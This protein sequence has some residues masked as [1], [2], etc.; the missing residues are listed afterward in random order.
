MMLEPLL[1][2]DTKERILLFLVVRG[3]GYAA[4]IARFYGIAASS[5]HRQLDN[6]EYG[7][8]LIGRQIG[9]CRDFTRSALVIRSKAN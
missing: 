8:V 7:D 1:G 2:N 9:R 5:V 6:L 4:E 3:S